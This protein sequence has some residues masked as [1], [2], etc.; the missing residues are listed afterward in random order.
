[1]QLFFVSQKS[2]IF[3]RIDNRFYYGTIQNRFLK[4]IDN[5]ILIIINRFIKYSQFIFISIII[6]ITK[7]AE[8]FYNQIELEYR[9]PDRIVSDYESI[10]N[11]KF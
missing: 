1:M 9:N 2:F 5:T 4:K 7:F 8:L 11:S 10:F 6:N 3:C